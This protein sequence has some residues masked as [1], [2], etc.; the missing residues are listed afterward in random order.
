[1]VAIELLKFDEISHGP[2]SVWVGIIVVAFVCVFI[3]WLFWCSW[4]DRRKEN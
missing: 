1:M 3:G 2:I 4:R